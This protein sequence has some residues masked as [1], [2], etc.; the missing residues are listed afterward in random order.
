MVICSDSRTAHLGSRWSCSVLPVRDICGKGASG[1]HTRSPRS[2][3]L[4]EPCPQVPFA[5]LKNMTSMSGYVS[6]TILTQLSF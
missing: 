3:H 4:R 6:Y 5:I 1:K 2:N